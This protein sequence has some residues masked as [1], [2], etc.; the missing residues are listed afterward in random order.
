MNRNL[1]RKLLLYIVDQLRDMEGEVSTI[2]LVKL[3]YLIDLEYFNNH[4]SLL[5]GIEWA[6]YSYGPYFFEL[7]D[8]LRSASIDLDAR[9]VITRSGRGFTFKTLEE[10]TITKDVDFATEQQIN[11]IL[12][13]WALEDTRSLLAYVYNTLPIKSGQRGNPLDF[14]QPLHKEEPMVETRKQISNPDAYRLM[15][16]SESI[17]AREWDTP[18]EDKAWG[19]LSKAKS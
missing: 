2:R 11:R 17:L 3:L 18:E 8:V 6:Y 14:S 5:T 1:V 19:Y 12:K 16:A 9:E 7:N 15:L 4:G 13:K 10:Q